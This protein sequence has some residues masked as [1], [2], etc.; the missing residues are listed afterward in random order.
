VNGEQF[1]HSTPIEI[2]AGRRYRLAFQN[3]SDD[4]HPVH[5]HR[6]T[7]ELVRVNGRATAGVMKD[8]VVVPGFGTVDVDFVANDPGATLFHCHQTLHMDYGFMRLLTYA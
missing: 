3:R 1:E 2:R 7:F 6:H 8:T 5:L 4:P